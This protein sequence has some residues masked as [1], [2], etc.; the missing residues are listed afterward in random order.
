MRRTPPLIRRL[1]IEFET[2]CSVFKHWTNVFDGKFVNKC[3]TFSQLFFVKITSFFWLLISFFFFNFVSSPLS[4]LSSLLCALPHV[5]DLTQLSP[6][7]WKNSPTSHNS[8]P[9]S[10]N[11]L[12]CTWVFRSHPPL[13]TLNRSP[14]SHNSHQTNNSLYSHPK[15]PKTQIY[16]RNHTPHLNKSHS[17]HPSRIQ[18]LIPTV[19]SNAS[20][21]HTIYH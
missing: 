19:A 20:K 17:P 11:S 8:H 18:P 12:L 14:T 21:S 2:Q 3:N 16:K 5:S 4:H 7:K 10:N 9:T 13:I 15:S 1:V 6:Q